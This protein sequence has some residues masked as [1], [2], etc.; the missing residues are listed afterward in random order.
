MVRE[1]F[2]TLPSILKLFNLYV[3]LILKN[4]C[5]RQWHILNPWVRPTGNLWNVNKFRSPPQTLSKSESLA[6]RHDYLPTSCTMWR[7]PVPTQVP[8]PCSGLQPPTDRPATQTK[9]AEWPTVAFVST[10]SCSPTRLSFIPINV[11]PH[12]HEDSTFV[13]CDV[14]LLGE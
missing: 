11:Y 8:R 6:S 9:A 7:W 10:K 3:H 13:G 14:V 2:F 12:R 4:S 1:L 5:V